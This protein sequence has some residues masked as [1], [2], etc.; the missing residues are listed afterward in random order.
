MIGS[1]TFVRPTDADLL[2]QK[3]LVAEKARAFAG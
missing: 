1:A 2:A 3:V